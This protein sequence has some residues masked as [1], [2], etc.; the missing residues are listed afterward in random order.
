MGKSSAAGASQAA[1]DWGGIGAEG[2]TADPR[3]FDQSVELSTG[4]FWTFIWLEASAFHWIS[5][6]TC[7][8]V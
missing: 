5:E 3:V 1:W 4:M 8:D 2:R 6:I 7:V